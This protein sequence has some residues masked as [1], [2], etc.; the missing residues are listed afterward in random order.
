M[1]IWPFLPG[2]LAAYA[3]LLI[4]A[5]SPG[6]AV[7]MLLGISLEQGRQ[8]ALI[9]SGGIAMGSMTLNIGTMIGV[10][11]LLSQVAW[12]MTALKFVGAAYLLYLAIAAFRKAAHPPEITVA[13]VEPQT[14]PRLL[15][16]GYLLQVTNPKAVVFWLA[17]AAI[18]ATEG[19]GLLIAAL[20]IIGGFVLSFVCHGA[21]SI[22]LSA[23]HFR[24]LYASARRNVEAALGM[25]FAVAAVK[26]ATSRT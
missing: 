10:G 1:D 2:F 13:E 4:G 22:F 3:I 20:F 18:G 17:I 11:I 19:G 24:R 8:A 5:S 23:G 9:T 21:W 25:F 14:W 15:M 16:S 6:P 7:A 26:L 12:A